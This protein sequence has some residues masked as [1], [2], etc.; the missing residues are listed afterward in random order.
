[1]GSSGAKE[2]VVLGESVAQ[3]AVEHEKVD[4]YV[5]KPLSCLQLQ[6]LFERHLG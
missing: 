3:P 4:D 1:V 6:E 2:G 5:E